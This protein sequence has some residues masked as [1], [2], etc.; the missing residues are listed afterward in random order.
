MFQSTGD[1]KSILKTCRCG[2]HDP[3]R[4]LFFLVFCDSYSKDVP[5]AIG[6]VSSMYPY[7]KCIWPRVN[8]EHI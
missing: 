2:G 1:N 8:K 3:L 6:L 7:L 4:D 5:G